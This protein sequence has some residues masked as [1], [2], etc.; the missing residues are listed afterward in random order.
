MR[1]VSNRRLVEFSTRYPD[2]HAALQAWRKLMEATEFGS[3]ADIRRSFGSVDVIGDKYA[4]DIRGNRYRL[5]TAV[6][7]RLQICYIKAVLTHTEYDRG[8]WR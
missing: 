8:T 4:F 7:F 5:I 3:F 1:V 6:S 2:A